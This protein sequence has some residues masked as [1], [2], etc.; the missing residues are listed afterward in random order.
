MISRDNLLC[1]VTAE[2]LPH[3]G[4]ISFAVTEV[5][6]TREYFLLQRLG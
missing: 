1:L 3:E 5:Y 6:P 4:V 2:V